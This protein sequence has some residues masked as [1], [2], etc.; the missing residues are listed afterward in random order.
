MATALGLRVGYTVR[1]LFP[2]GKLTPLGMTTSEKSFQVAAIFESGLWD[3]DSNWAYTSM[4][5]ARRLF[6][7]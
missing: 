3:Y 6:G 4:A 7:R 5:A 1:V 2:M